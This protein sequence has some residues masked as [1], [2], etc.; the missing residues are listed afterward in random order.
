NV[1][2]P[3]LEG[4][5]SRKGGDQ[6]HRQPPLRIVSQLHGVRLL[7]K[8]ESY[9]WSVKIG[10]KT[11]LFH[12]LQKQ[13]T[14]PHVAI[15]DA[16]S[17]LLQS[18]FSRSLIF[19]HD[20]DEIQL[21]L[22][23]FPRGLRK[24]GAIAPDGTA[25]SDEVDGFLAFF[26]SC[27]S[28]C[29]KTPYR[30]L[31]EGLGIVSQIEGTEESKAAYTPSE[32]PS[33]LLFTI[34]EELRYRIGKEKGSISSDI[35]TVFVFLRRF[36]LLLLGKQPDLRYVSHLARGLERSA[37]IEGWSGVIFNA[38]QRELKIL[39]RCLDFGRTADDEMPSTASP[40]ILKEFMSPSIGQGLSWQYQVSIFI[41][42]LRFDPTVESEDVVMLMAST[43]VSLPGSHEA[44]RE[45]LLNV[46]SPGVLWALLEYDDEIG[47]TARQSVPFHWAFVQATDATL[48]SDENVRILASIFRAEAKRFASSASRNTNLVSLRVQE[49]ISKDVPLAQS[50]GPSVLRMLNLAL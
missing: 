5:E 1:V 7:E 46:F 39:R 3:I 13:M 50:C 23:S 32:V 30:Y 11:A 17:S 45:L 9:D 2:A 24:Q 22:A 16:A 33:P 43:L 21:W 18:F 34:L 36:F 37:E 10:P 14:T 48:K 29:L 19:E 42:R 26:D 4:E 47:E 8:L 35:L 15:R 12:V 38:V 41:D 27:L 31:E 28:R 44:V 49:E 6:S 20:P 25:L 40:G